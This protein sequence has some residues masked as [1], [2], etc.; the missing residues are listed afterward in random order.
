M[1]M[2]VITGRS[3]IWSSQMPQVFNQMYASDGFCINLCYVLLNFC[4]PFT[5]IQAT[6]KLLKI[7]P[8]YT[9]FIAADSKHAQKAGVHTE[10]TVKCFIFAGSNFRGF[11]NWTYSR[12]LKFAS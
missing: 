1:H 11:H 7:Q 5:A 9:G 2:F 8:S 6:D 12:G 4:K 10:G 3:K